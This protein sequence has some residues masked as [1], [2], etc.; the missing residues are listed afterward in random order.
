MLTGR[1][2]PDGTVSTS[3]GP[4]GPMANGVDQC[5]TVGTDGERADRVASGVDDEQEP[6]VVGEH[7]TALVAQAASGAAAAGGDGARGRQLTVHVAIEDQD[8]VAAGRVARD[9][10]GADAGGECAGHGEG[11]HHGGQERSG[12][13]AF[14]RVSSCILVGRVC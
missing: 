4:S 14:H 8:L 7:Q 10:N 9:V 6:L 11:G 13:K 2:P 1:T 3:A 12:Q 5:G